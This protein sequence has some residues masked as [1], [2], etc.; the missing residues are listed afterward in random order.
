MVGS[1]LGPMGTAVGGILG[2]IVGF[3]RSMYKEINTKGKS[4]FG[5][6]GAKSAV[7]GHKLAA[8]G[9]SYMADGAVMPNGNVIKTAKGKM[10]NLSPR[11]VI[12]VGQP[13]GSSSYGGGSNH[14]VTVGGTINL[15]SGGSS[16]SL[17]GLMNDP[18]FKAEITKVVIDGMKNNNR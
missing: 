15:S 13:G 18:V 14:T 8:A 4:D 6:S 9:T 11:D 17:D 1:M 7:G 16:I 5:M 3:G 2:G 10:F 12:S